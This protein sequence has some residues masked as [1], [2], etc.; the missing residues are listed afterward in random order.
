MYRGG[1]INKRK[2]RCWRPDGFFSLIGL[3]LLSVF[4]SLSFVLLQQAQ[5]LSAL[6]KAQEQVTLYTALLDFVKTQC[7]SASEEIRLIDDEQQED[8]E[9]EEAK[10]EAITH[11][12]LWIEGKSYEIDKQGDT[13]FI[14]QGNT[15]ILEID[16]KEE[17]IQKV[18]Y[19]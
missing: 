2:R 15:A 19:V 4:L 17:H 10:E 12:Q 13:L 6:A 14:T 7:L 18:R 1:A 9:S 8:E 11:W 3:F 16:C 5:A